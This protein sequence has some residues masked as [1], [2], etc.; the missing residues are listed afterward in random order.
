METSAQHVAS[1]SGRPQLQP[2]SAPWAVAARCHLDRC[3]GGRASS[4]PGRP[5]LARYLHCHYLAWILVVACRGSIVYFGVSHMQT[6]ASA[7]QRSMERV[8][9]EGSG[10]RETVLRSSEQVADVCVC[11]WSVMSALRH[12]ALASSSYQV[13][14]LVCAGASYHQRF[15]LDCRKDPARCAR[16]MVAKPG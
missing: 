9:R 7:S 10:R 15:A 4:E 11:V 1:M 8:P 13:L 12:I 2:D 5:R 6:S 16:Y 3:G 14:L